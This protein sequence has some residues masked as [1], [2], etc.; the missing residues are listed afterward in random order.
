VIGADDHFAVAAVL[1]GLAF[2]GFWVEGNALGRKVSGVVWVISLG[3]LLGNTGIVPLDAPAYGLVGGTLMPMAIPLLLF[4]ADMRRIFRESGRVLFGFVFAAAGTVLGALI[5]F[6]LL[7]LGA[8]GAKAAGVY[9][10]G[11]IGGAVDFVAVSEALEMTSEE[12]AVAMGASSPVSVIALMS[13]AALPSIALLRRFVPSR[14]ID[15]TD[16]TSANIEVTVQDMKLLH[17]LGA[18]A[19]AAGICALAAWVSSWSGY[20]QYNILIITLLSLAVANLFPAHLGTLEGEFTLGM[21]I[22]FVF[23]AAIG[24]STDATAFLGTAVVLFFYGLIIIF[25]HLA[26]VLAAARLFRIDLAEM[27]IASAAAMVGP[28]PAAAIAS[29]RGWSHL[30]TPALMCGVFGYAIANF[31]GVAVARA[32]GAM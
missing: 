21:L 16:E 5:G 29:A 23:F 13:L 22:M 10:A 11:W 2:F 12:F 32:F 24:C 6:L 26:V 30:V 9:T 17:T 3:I 1:L 14:H 18:L 25:V 7:D 19:L 27:I 8:I 20:P 4:K 28:A 31:I 15:T